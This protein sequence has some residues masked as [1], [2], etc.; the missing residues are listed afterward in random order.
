MKLLLRKPPGYVMASILCSLGGFL[1]GV[2]TSIIGPVTVMDK[3]TNSFGHPS[4][5][6]HGL[7]VSSILIPAAIS[8]IFAGRVADALGRPTAI[9]IGCAIFGLGAAIEAAA[10][11]LGMFVAGR[12]VA[13]TG[14]GLYLGTLV[15]YICE[16]SPA[17]HRGALT[18]GPQLLVT[19][20]LVVGFFTC[21][22]S[23]DI[24]STISWRLPFILLASYSTI[25]AVIAF[26]LLP[27]SPRW[28]ADRHGRDTAAVT[29]AWESLG[30]LAADREI[31]MDQ[32]QERNIKAG[33]MM[34]V[35]S[36]E[37]RPR[38]FLA[39]FLMGMQ[40]LSGIDGVLYYAPLLF[41]QAGIGSAGNSFLASGMSAV[42]ICAVTIP[43]T[44]LADRWSRRRNTIYGGIGMAG[45]MF[46]LGGLYAGDAVHTYG[47]GR[48]IA[49]VSIYVFIVIFSISW[50]VGMRIYAAEIQPQRTRAS[51][52][53][54]AYG[55]NW[56][57][58]F[59]VALVTPTLLANTG[60]GAYFLFGSCTFATVVV[61]WFF[62]PETRGR[63]LDEIQQAFH[64]SHGTHVSGL[65]DSARALKLRIR[66]TPAIAIT[67]D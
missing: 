14:E 15:V 6:L 59:L 39:V 22:G 31:M 19:C 36:A 13:G 41:Q 2:D 35:F 25:V 43:A 65:W 54:I 64:G 28:L 16:I 12:V 33:S 30:V 9:S 10:I 3:F 45:T 37:S 40:Q 58:N 38:L 55:S 56:V 50:A 44:I 29:A 66:R 4:P 57:T 51:A 8:S 5:T 63:T 42:V 11:H 26:L 49:V 46:V 61:C 47:A 17:R 7:I 18:T 32:F 20:G 21:Y 48:W 23:V 27:P 1:F 52:T 67:E 34:D 24:K 60:Y 62:M 53:S